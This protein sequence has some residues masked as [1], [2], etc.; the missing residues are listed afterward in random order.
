MGATSP[1]SIDPWPSRE[2]RRLSRCMFRK[3]GGSNEGELS[4]SWSIHKK[5]AFI[6]MTK[7][8]STTM[9]WLWEK[10]SN[11]HEELSYWTKSQFPE[12]VVNPLSSVCH[13]IPTPETR[14]HGY[15]FHHLTVFLDNYLTVVRQFKDRIPLCCFANILTKTKKFRIRLKMGG[16]GK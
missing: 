13:Y 3:R 10:D 7:T 6:M 12:L 8:L 5:S 14:G 15:L 2:A 1:F 11:L 16:F 4:G 9:Y